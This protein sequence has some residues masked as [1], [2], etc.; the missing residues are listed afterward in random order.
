M[1]AQNNTMHLLVTLFYIAFAIMA[2]FIF[3]GCSKITIDAVSKATSK[4]SNPPEG[5][6]NMNSKV[7]LILASSKSNNTSKIA[8]VFASA[9]D[10]TVK[11]PLQIS[12]EELRNFTLIGF[13]SGI[14][15]QKHHISLLELADKLPQQPGQK[16]FIFSTSGFSRKFAL[17]HSTDDTHTPLREKL[18]AKGFIIVDEFNCLGF[19][20]NSFLK[21]FGGMNKGRPN[22]NDLKD[23]E[24]F[25]RNLK[26]KWLM[27]VD[28]SDTA[29]RGLSLR[30]SA[31]LSGNL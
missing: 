30:N 5:N 23:A 8:N 14:F 22:E 11:S 15:S 16:A 25:A 26:E 17:E 2:W 4:L 24:G 20:R 19:N 28:S 13:G 1:R 27:A 12:P 18:K 6:K 21:L 31:V 10:A 9:L 3:S 29:V 7:L